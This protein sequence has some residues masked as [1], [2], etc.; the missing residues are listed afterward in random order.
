LKISLFFLEFYDLVWDACIFGLNAKRSTGWKLQ[1]RNQIGLFF[2][3]DQSNHY[4]Y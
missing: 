1:K 2:L 3:L 4:L